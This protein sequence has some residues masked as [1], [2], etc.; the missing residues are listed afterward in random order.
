MDYI[1]KLKELSDLSCTCT[2]KQSTGED[3]T[4]CPSCTAGNILTQIMEIAENEFNRFF[5]GV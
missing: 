2:E 4:L 5:T 1:E 3:Y